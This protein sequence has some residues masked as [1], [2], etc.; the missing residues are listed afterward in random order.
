MVLD[1][2]QSAACMAEF[3]IQ[4]AKF[5]DMAFI[6]PTTREYYELIERT[7][8]TIA[9][10]QG[11]TSEAIHGLEPPASWGI[12][13]EHGVTLGDLRKS[14]HGSFFVASGMDDEDHGEGISDQFSTS[15]MKAN[16]TEYPHAGPCAQRM[17]SSLVFSFF[18]SL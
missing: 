9:Q 6:W 1:G 13:R 4:G 15:W 17:F 12:P 11:L 2:E 14:L 16:A 18:P 8:D 10:E 5:E 7:Y 3:V